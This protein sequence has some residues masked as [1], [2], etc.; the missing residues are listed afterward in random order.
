MA[1]TY[2]SGRRIQG[3]STDSV[4]LTSFDTSTE[5]GFSTSTNSITK[6]SGSSTWGDSKIQSTV[7]FAVGTPFAVEFS[8]SSSSATGFAGLGQGGLQHNS[9]S[10]LR[11][12]DSMIY[13]L[14]IA[15][16]SKVTEYDGVAGGTLKNTQATFNASDVYRITVSGSGLVKYWRQA[17][18]SGDFNLEYTSTKTA[19]GSYYFQCNMHTNGQGFASIKFGKPTNVQVGSRFE[20]TDTRKIYYR[21]DIDFKE[22]DGAEATNY[23]SESWYE[24][25]TGETP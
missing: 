24:Q 17:S 11:M 12:S 7:S 14:Y 22:L 3:L 25:L 23:R 6:D 20:E 2:H 1:I 10:G 5:S 8:P 19:S 18:G 9:G 4:D 16:E 21:D 15:G 13:G